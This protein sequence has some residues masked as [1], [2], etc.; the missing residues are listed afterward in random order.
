M[1]CHRC[2]HVVRT[3]LC[4]VCLR[5]YQDRCASARDEEGMPEILAWWL[6]AIAL[7]YVLARI[8][9]WYMDRLP[10]HRR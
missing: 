3:L 9:G 6:G 4:G 7:A 10:H 8:A 1:L 5:C 2:R